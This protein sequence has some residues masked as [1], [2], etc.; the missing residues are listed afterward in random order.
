L[1]F[2]S[3]WLIKRSLIDIEKLLDALRE[4]ILKSSNFHQNITQPKRENGFMIVS[5]DPKTNLAK[6]VSD[7]L[8]EEYKRIK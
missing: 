5:L 2:L 8:W 1:T 4:E 3:S 6:P 7:E